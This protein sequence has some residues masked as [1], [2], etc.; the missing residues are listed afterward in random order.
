MKSIGISNNMSFPNT[1]D[2]DMLEYYLGRALTVEEKSIIY[3]YTMEEAFNDKLQDVYKFCKSKNLHA[4]ILTSLAGDCLFESLVYF[5]IGKNVGELRKTVS[6]LLYIFKDYK[7]LIPDNDMTLKQLFDVTNEI[8]YVKCSDG[9]F[10]YYTYDTMCQDVTNMQSWT[11]L[12]TQLILMVI[13]YVFKLKI[14]I[15]NNNGNYE[16]VINTFKPVKTDDDN[17]STKIKTIYLGHVQ[18]AHYFPLDYNH[19]NEDYI[20]YN[21]CYNVLNQWVNYVQD[22]KNSGKRY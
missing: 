5:G 4:P 6:L 18:E 12:P 2:H 15:L 11:K 13:S 1:L 22:P 3:D 14:I 17:N 8:K 10:Y 16:N 7:Y 19:N 21:D 20:Y 9:K